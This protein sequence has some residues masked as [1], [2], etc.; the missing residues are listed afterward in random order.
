M[1]FKNISNKVKFFK[2]S[3]NMVA[4]QPEGCIDLP[5]HADQSEKGLAPC[6]SMVLAKPKELERYIPFKSEEQLKKMT[7][8]EINDYAARIGYSELKTSFLKSN[9]IKAVLR[10][11]NEES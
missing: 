3:G 10:Y 6:G 7:K 2:I 11:Q 5:E 4:V 8:D 1:K 9:M